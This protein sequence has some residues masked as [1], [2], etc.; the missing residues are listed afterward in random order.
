MAMDQ[1]LAEFYGTNKTAS[2]PQ[3]DLEKQATAELFLKVATDQKVDL[4]SMSEAQVTALFNDFQANQAKLAG[5]SETTKTAAA[6][7]P[8]R[9]QLEKQAQEEFSQKQASAEKIAEADFLGRVMAHACVNEMSKIATGQ[10]TAADKC[11]KC[12]EGEHEGEC[13][14]DKTAELPE[15]LRAHMMKGKEEGKGKEEKK[16]HEEKHE[17]KHEGK[18][19]SAIDNLAYA[20]ALELAKTANYNLEEAAA[21]MQAAYTLGLV[22]ESTKVA[23]AQDLPTAVHVRA[24]ELLEAAKYKVDWN[25]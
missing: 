8:T 6:A 12:G 3:E 4:K 14:K 23:A 18:S 20:K 22:G 24:L 10:K 7:E 15:A 17:D 25:A 1:F 13:K 19:A 2:A 21:R 9:E 16:E 5:A 11:A